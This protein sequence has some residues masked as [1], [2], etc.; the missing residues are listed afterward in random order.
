[1][2]ICKNYFALTADAVDAVACAFLATAEALEAAEA[3]SA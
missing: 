3:F 1:L 2:S